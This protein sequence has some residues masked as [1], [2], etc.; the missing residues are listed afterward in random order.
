MNLCEAQVVKPYFN[1][2]KKLENPYGICSHFTFTWKRGDYDT[3][4]EQSQMLSSI[5]CNNVRFD[6]TYNTINSMNTAPLDTILPVLKKYSISPLIVFFD[7]RLNAI[8]WNEADTYYDEQL[9][10]IRNHYASKIKY[11]EFQN[12]VNYSKLVNLG[13]HYTNDLKKVYDLKKKKLKIVFSGI[14][15]WHFDFL[16]S[17]LPYKAYKYFDIMN[18]H[19]YRKPEDMPLFLEN[20]KRNMVKYHWNK[21][22]WLTECGMNT[23]KYDLS[24]SNYDFFT[25]VVPQAYKRIGFNIINLKV[26]VICDTTNSY[27]SLNNFE[28]KH[29]ITNLSAKPCLITFKDFEYLSPKDVPVIVLTSDQ[30][31][32]SKYFPS[33]LK[34]VKKGGTI[35]LPYGNPFYFDSSNNNKEVGKAYIQQLHVGQLYWWEESAKKLSAPKQPSFYSASKDFGIEYIFNK[36]SLKNTLRYLTDT[37][38]QGG[39]KMIPIC[40][41]GNDKFKGVVA[42]L[43]NLNSDLKGNVIIQTCTDTNRL[44]DLEDEQA[45]L[46][47]RTY[48]ISFAYG[49]DKVFWYEFRS[50]EDNLYYSEDNFGILHKD[51]SPKPAYNAFKTLIKMLPSGSSRPLLTVKDNLYRAEWETPDGKHVTAY[52]CSKGYTKVLLDG[53][54]NTIYDYM[55]RKYNSINE[56]VYAKT[57]V[58]YILN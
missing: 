58:T 30:S 45:R 16:D 56:T 38:L 37:K 22:V 10:I 26:G 33:V 14:S 39:D 7:R 15:D 40:Y 1:G 51:L 19:S 47:A 20:L 46:I 32:P 50:M 25:K 27:F 24:N 29:Y 53:N 34:Y 55:G 28:I 9:N 18:F 21:P 43:Y 13:F 12:E 23:A 5:G 3:F 42:A 17:V 44:I 8:K 41:G 54:N 11:I 4:Q 2:T 52:W 6:I 36:A 49:V 31:F 35:I 57:G 48:L